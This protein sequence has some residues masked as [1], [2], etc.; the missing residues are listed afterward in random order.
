MASA[1][2]TQPAAT[3]SLP[4][5]AVAR[6]TRDAQKDGIFAG[7]SAGLVGAIIGQRLYRFDRNRAILA[8]VVTGILAGY[9]FTQVFLASNLARLR[10]EQAQLARANDA[11][12]AERF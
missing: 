8:G 4:V 2:A 9:Q 5:D 6:C 1:Q 3:A 10:Q 7:L 11:E 12:G